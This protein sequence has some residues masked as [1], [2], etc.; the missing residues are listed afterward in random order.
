MPELQPLDRIR[1]YLR[2]VNENVIEANDDLILPIVGDEG[3]GKSTLMAQIVWLWQDIRADEPTP[4][5]VIDRMVWGERPA[6]KEAL[7]EGNQG[8]AIAVQDAAHVLYAKEAMVGEQV[9]IEKALLDIR[10]NNYLILLGFQD[11]SDIPDGL[12]RRRAKN[13]IRVIR[14]GWERGFYEAYGRDELDEKYEELAKNEWPEPRF[15]GRFP[16]LEGTDLWQRFTERDDE[17]KTE[18]LEDSQEVEP[19]DARREEAIKTVLRAVQPWDDN[20][21][22]TQQEASRLV[23]YSRGWV[24]QRIQDWRAGDYR[25]LVNIEGGDERA[26]AAG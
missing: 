19:D 7:L 8:Q 20:G 22:M 9:D 13:T 24:S 2:A 26:T 6:F 12:R 16:S 11:W 17:K 25:D 4:D 3:A 10:V 23:D 21:G 15:D 1:T 5:S 14:K 18:R